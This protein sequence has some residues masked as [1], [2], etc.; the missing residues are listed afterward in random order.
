[1]RWAISTPGLSHR[2]SI[3]GLKARP[4]QADLDVGHG[5]ACFPSQGIDDGSLD[6]IRYPFGI[7]VVDIAGQ[8][9]D[10]GPIRAGIDGEP[11]GERNA[12]AADSSPRLRDIDTW[13][14]VSQNDE[15]PDADA[16]VTVCVMPPR[17]R[18]FSTR[19]WTTRPGD[20]V[21]GSRR[22][23]HRSFLV[24]RQSW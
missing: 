3:S 19:S 24:R 15:F 14:A 13:V 17:T 22:F 10:A 4:R 5:A 20:L 1:M 18:S 6:L 7:V 8:A 9:D 12:A 16:Y 2:S 23:A 11:G 21:P